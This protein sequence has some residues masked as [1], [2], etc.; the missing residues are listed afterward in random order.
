[1]RGQ[2]DCGHAPGLG[3]CLH[4]P[5]ARGYQAECVLEAEDA[6]DAG[7]DVLADAVS[8]EGRGTQS[9]TQPQASEG[10]LDGEQRRLGVRGVGQVLGSVAP[11]DFEQG[12]VEVIGQQGRA[13]V[14]GGAKGW[15]GSVQ[16]AAHAR[17]LSALAG[18]QPGHARVGG[19]RDLAV[20]NTRSGWVRQPGGELL[21]GGIDVWRDHGQAVSEVTAG[22]GGGSADVGQ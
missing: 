14:D 19:G 3:Q 1:M 10:P 17:V 7:G 12:L 16:L 22:G 4:E 13:A 2:L 9:P 18:K 5:A 8:D 21:A 15:L 6:G 11:Q 20:E